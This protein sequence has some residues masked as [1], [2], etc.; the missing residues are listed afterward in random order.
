VCW[1]PQRRPLA[2]ASVAG[3][4]GSSDRSGTWVERRERS[5]WVREEK[6]TAV[7]G[8]ASRRNAQ[9][10]LIHKAQRE[11]ETI[12]RR[13]YPWGYL[14]LSKRTVFPGG[15]VLEKGSNFVPDAPP[16][17]LP[18]KFDSLNKCRVTLDP[19][20]LKAKLLPRINNDLRASNPGAKPVVRVHVFSERYYHVDFVV[21]GSVWKFHKDPPEF[22]ELDWLLVN[23]PVFGRCRLG[24]R[25]CR[26]LPDALGRN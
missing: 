20:Y 18:S 21:L 10:P 15:I 24:A 19:S 25:R 14:K 26:S 23:C 9:K 11:T 1:D 8:G 2:D 22:G 17:D 13:G 5:P 3:R 16:Y 6:R 4:F 7:G 12:P